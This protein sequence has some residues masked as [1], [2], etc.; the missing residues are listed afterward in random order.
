MKTLKEGI[1]ELRTALKPMTFGEKITHLWMYYKWVLFA[2]V[3]VVAGISIVVNA[4]TAKDPLFNGMTMNIVVK[5]EAKA[6]LTD[7]WKAVLGGEEKDRVGLEV[8]YNTDEAV[9]MGQDA[10]SSNLKM[11]MMISSCQLDYVLLDQQA[12]GE[13]VTAGAFGDLRELLPQEQ[14]ELLGKQIC[15][16][17]DENENTYPI[18]V[19]ISDWAFTKEYLSYAGKAFL[20]FPG[21]TERTALLSEFLDYIWKWEKP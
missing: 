20:A 18:A 1:E 3:A 14:L 6:Y 9:M 21:N 5:E 4:I 19:D 10:L 13:F 17:K 11:S 12:M 8:M 15:Y 2:V 16:Y 7:G